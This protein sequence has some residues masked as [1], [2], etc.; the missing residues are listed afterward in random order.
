MGRREQENH[1]SNDAPHR[2]G[3]T[4]DRQPRCLCGQLRS[5]GKGTADVAG[6]EANQ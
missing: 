1:G 3:G 2:S 4:Q 5:I 6:N